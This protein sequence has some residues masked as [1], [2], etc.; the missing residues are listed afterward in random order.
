VATVAARLTAAAA[1]TV[2][3]LAVSGLAAPALA[4]DDCGAAATQRAANACEHERFVA[5]QAPLGEA[6]RALSAA[7][8]PG[9]R[10]ALRREQKAWLAWRTA[11]CDVEASGVAGGSAAPMLRARCATRLT[12]AR[13]DALRRL[14]DCPEGDLACPARRP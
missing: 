9:P 11:A 6:Y 2:S 10:D 1:A 5:A 14:L 3:V 4:Q 13:T 12:Q 8:A 7:L